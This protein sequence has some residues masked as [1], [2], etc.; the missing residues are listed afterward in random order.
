M[1]TL[2]FYTEEKKNKEVRI[3][4]R[5]IAEVEMSLKHGDKY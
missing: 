4:A 3:Q 1:K 5:F 2:N